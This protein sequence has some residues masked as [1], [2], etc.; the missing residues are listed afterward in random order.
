MSAPNRFRPE[1][2]GIFGGSFDPIHW[3]HLELARTAFWTVPLDQVA[4]VPARQSPHKTAGGEAGPGDRAEMVRRAIEG[5]AGFHL[6]PWELHRPGLS[7]SIDTVRRFQE[8]WPNAD[9]FWIL[10]SDQWNTLETWRAWEEL[11]ERVA[12]IVFPRPDPPSPRPGVRLI[13]LDFRSD[14]SSTDIREAVRQGRPWQHF[15]PE[16][17]ADYITTRHLYS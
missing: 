4:F 14:I 8:R 15:V 5:Q 7:Y 17:V 2:I 12:F 1:R 9:L 16:P 3:A 13:P 6:V 10:G 11:A